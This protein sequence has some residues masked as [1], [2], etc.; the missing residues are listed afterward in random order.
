MSYNL[1]AKF[2]S[3]VVI[4]IFMSLMTTVHDK[5]LLTTSVVEIWEIQAR[6]RSASLFAF[7][8]NFNATESI[9]RI[10]T[11][12]SPLERPRQVFEMISV[13]WKAAGDSQSLPLLR[14]F[15]P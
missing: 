2:V 12:R 9:S 8:Q 15:L 1:K 13:V 11:E 6:T 4:I 5:I 3:L 10:Q 14:F 7:Q